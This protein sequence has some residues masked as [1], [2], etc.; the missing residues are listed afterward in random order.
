KPLLGYNV[1]DTKLVVVPEEAEQVRQI[2]RLYAD[3]DGLTWVAQQLEQRGWCNKRWTTRKGTE[4]GGRP[5]DKT[6]LYKL[7]TNVAYIGKVRYKDEVH[8][9]EHQAIVPDELWQRVQA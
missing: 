5:F 8:P 1:V 4:C 2:F 3:G 6:S 9:G 7:V